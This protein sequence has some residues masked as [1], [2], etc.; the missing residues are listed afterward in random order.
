M[1]RRA[2]IRARVLPHLLALIIAYGLAFA[3]LAD[4]SEQT[5]SLPM[6]EA[7]AGLATLLIKPA[8]TGRYPL[9]I[10]THGAPRDRTL[11]SVMSPDAYRAPA[12]EFT[13]RGWAVAIVMRRGF[14]ATGGDFAESYGQCNDPNY[15]RA[16]R[17]AAADLKFAIAALQKR[18]DIDG[19]RMIAVGHSA[20]GFASVALS[21]DPPQGL[22]GAISFAGGRGSLKDNEVCDEARLVSA[23]ATFG[24]TSRIPML[25]VYSENDQY[26][27]PE[28]AEKLRDA[29]V[30]GGGKVEFIKAAP[31]GRDGHTLFA[32]G[33]P[34]WTPLVDAFL[35]KQ[36]LIAAP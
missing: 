13:R 21:A 31:F 10:L 26:F 35:A 24:K 18:A 12:M 8:E 36:K 32:R 29:F 16:G 17:S 22:V 33:I 34:V 25:W 19:T 9:A 28:L 5:L 7:P 2:G 11:R 4:V 20:G 14:G 15:V 23:F 1:G 3:A 27:S 30:A 6:P